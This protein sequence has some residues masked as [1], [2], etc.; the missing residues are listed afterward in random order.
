MKNTNL[1]SL[2]ATKLA[3]KNDGGGGSRSCV[4]VKSAD[5]C[6]MRGILSHGGDKIILMIAAAKYRGMREVCNW[7][8]FMEVECVQSQP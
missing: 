5:C 6:R 8:V 7:Q 4:Q 2:I 1:F 3:W